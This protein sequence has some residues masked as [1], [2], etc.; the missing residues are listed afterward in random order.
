MVWVIGA[1]LGSTFENHETEAA[2]VGTDSTSEYPTI[3]SLEYIMSI[4]NAVHT[5]ERGPISLPMPNK[6]YFSTLYNIA[7]LQFSF[8]TDDYLMFYY[9]VIMPF[10]VVAVLSFAILFIGIIR[11]NITWG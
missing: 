10:V 6:E 9:I 5:T 8:I 1:L 4:D 2:W 11:G 7:T 3:N